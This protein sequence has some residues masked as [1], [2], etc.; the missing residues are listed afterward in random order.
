MSSDKETRYNRIINANKARRK[1][2]KVASKRYQ[3]H[4]AGYGG[5]VELDPSEQFHLNKRNKPTWEA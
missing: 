2:D 4:E 3:E 1:R 5:N